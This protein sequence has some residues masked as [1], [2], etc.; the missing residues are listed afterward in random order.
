M[1]KCTLLALGF[2]GSEFL[3]R[4]LEIHEQIIHNL[5]MVPTNTHLQYGFLVKIIHTRFLE[6]IG[7]LFYKELDNLHKLLTSPC[8][9]QYDHLSKLH[10]VV[11]TLTNSD[12]STGA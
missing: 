2:G 5:N 10:T 11:L 4:P 12:S 8:L 1:Y 7:S 3:L 6:Y 9:R